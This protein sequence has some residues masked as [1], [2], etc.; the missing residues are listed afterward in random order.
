MGRQGPQRIWRS[1]LYGIVGY[2][3]ATLLLT[4]GYGAS[5]YGVVGEVI[6]GYGV[7]GEEV[8]GRVEVG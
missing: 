2:L 1:V 6:T 4:V 8:V 5:G 7:V 3:G